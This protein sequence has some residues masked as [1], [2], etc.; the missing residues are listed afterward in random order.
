MKSVLVAYNG[1]AHDLRLPAQV[2]SL[3]KEHRARLH[4]VNVA[5]DCTSAKYFGQ[6]GTFIKR[7]FMVLA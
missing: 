7:R 6:D 2:V 4:I 5:P 3:A 1:F